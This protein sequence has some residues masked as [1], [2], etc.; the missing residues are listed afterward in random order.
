MFIG[1]KNLKGLETLTLTGAL[2]M[3]LAAA[4]WSGQAAAQVVA[5]DVVC[6]G[7]VGTNDLANGAIGNQKLQDLSIG[8]RKLKN[9]AIGQ[10]KI[11]DDSIG[12]RKIKDGAIGQRKIKDDAIGRKKLKDNA[13]STAKI[14]DQAVTGDKIAPGSVTADKL[15]FALSPT[16]SRTPVGACGTLAQPGSYVVTQNLT[17]TGDCL[18]VSADYVTIDLNGF[19]LS[20]NQSGSGVA[21]Q[22]DPP[23]QG[24]VVRNGTIENFAQGVALAEAVECIIDGLRVFS[25]VLTGILSGEGCRVTNNMVADSSGSGIFSGPANLVS[26][27]VVEGAATTGIRVGRGSIVSENVVVGSGGTGVIMGPGTLLTSNTINGSAGRGIDSNDPSS[28]DAAVTNN[29]VTENDV[30]INY[31]YPVDA[32][33]VANNLIR[34]NTS[35]D[36]Q[37]TCGNCTVVHNR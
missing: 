35:S 1:H 17:A 7:C 21:I 29:V 33:L 12:D 15:A 26:R 25:T 32:L 6:S 4:G 9:G 22:E 31:K 3:G 11:K 14:A 8:D 27:N 10:N 36:Q 23:V 37:G 5:D 28:F 30:G 24:L 20:G 13:V 2:A 18:F 19:V 16:G 34:A